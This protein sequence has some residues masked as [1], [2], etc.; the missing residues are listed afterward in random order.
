MKSHV[1]AAPLL[2]SA[3]LFGGGGVLAQKAPGPASDPS[4]AQESSGTTRVVHDGGQKV[5]E[6]L[7]DPETA[8]QIQDGNADEV[9]RKLKS[10]RG[11]PSV[12]ELRKGAYQALLK[13]RSE[14][15]SFAQKARLLAAL[16]RLN[17]AP[18]SEIAAAEQLDLQLNPNCADVWTR[19]LRE[20]PEV[21]R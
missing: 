1:L 8:R 21:G 19:T 20:P 7:A 16:A 14:A 5:E 17:K 9:L 18:E 12:T 13:S 3:V 11:G 6:L 4:T 15:E 2:W 10:S